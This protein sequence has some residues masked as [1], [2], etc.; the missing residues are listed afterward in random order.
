[1]PGLPV[2][3]Y[4]PEACSNSG[5]LSQWCHPYIAWFILYGSLTVSCRWLN[6]IHFSKHVLGEI[7]GLLFL[8]FVGHLLNGSHTLAATIS[9][10]KVLFS[11]VVQSCLTLYNPMDCSTPVLPVHHQ[12]PEFTQTHVHW[13][14]CAFQPSHPPSSPSPPTFNVSQYQG[15]F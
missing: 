12:L 8:S 5:P 13:V 7:S 1:M 3:H 6:M 4:L 11:S 15:F 14:G 2:L 9:K 10:T